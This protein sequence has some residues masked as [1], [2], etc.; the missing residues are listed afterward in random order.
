MGEDFEASTGSVGLG[1]MSPKTKL[2]A[3]RR[4]IIVNTTNLSG[5]PRRPPLTKSERLS[6]KNVSRS[7]PIREAIL[8]N[9]NSFPTPIK[10][11]AIP[12]RGNSMMT[13]GRTESKTGDLPV[14]EE[15]SEGS[16]I[17][18]GAGAGSKVGRRRANPN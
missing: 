8:K 7:I 3:R 4:S 11:F 14:E 15:A 5:C 17:C 9:S 10:S 12:R 16:S 1:M 6:E 18:S 2:Q 13:M